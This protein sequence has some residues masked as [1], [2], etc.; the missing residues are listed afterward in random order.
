MNKNYLIIVLLLIVAVGGGFFA[1]MKYQQT[2]SSAAR[3]GVYIFG[4]NGQSGMMRG[5]FGQNG[6]NFRPVRGQVASVDNNSLTVKLPNGNSMVVVLAP[7]TQYGKETSATSSDVKSGDTVMVLGT[8]NSDGSITA[9]NV[10]INP[11]VPQISPT[12]APTVTQ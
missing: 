8:Q 10:Q 7:S 1:G 5:R 2:K 12:A 3:N 9:S 11:P 4:Q 6:Q